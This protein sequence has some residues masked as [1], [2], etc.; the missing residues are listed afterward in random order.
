MRLA[1]AGDRH[2]G[3]IPRAVPSHGRSQVRAYKRSQ[4]RAYKRSQVRAYKRL[5]LSVSTDRE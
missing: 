4:V 5:Q 3:D 2:P 1:A